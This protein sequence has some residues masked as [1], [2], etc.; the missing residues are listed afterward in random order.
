MKTTAVGAMVLASLVLLVSGESYPHTHTFGSPNFHDTPE[1]DAVAIGGIAAGY[2][3]FGSLML[4]AFVRIWIDEF[5]RHK[6]YNGELA[7]DFKEMQRLEMP[8]DQIN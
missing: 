4:F 1:M 6:S 7:S 5:Q 3:V 8:I 2:A